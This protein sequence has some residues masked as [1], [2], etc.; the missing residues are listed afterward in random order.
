MHPKWFKYTLQNTEQPRREILTRIAGEYGP[1]VAYLL[2]RIRHDPPP[3]G[4][5]GG[6]SKRRNHKREK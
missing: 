4:G 6:K 3:P 5:A 2:A 1:L